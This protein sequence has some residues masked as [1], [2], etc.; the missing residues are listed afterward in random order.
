MASQRKAI[1]ADKKR[2]GSHFRTKEVMDFDLL[3]TVLHNPLSPDIIVEWYSSEM[4]AGY[5]PLKEVC[6][7]IHRCW[8]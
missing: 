2:K 6:I 4:N 5:L 7:F 1:A 8:L 3:S